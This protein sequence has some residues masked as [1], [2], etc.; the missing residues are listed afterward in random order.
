MW[1]GVTQVLGDRQILYGGEQYGRTD[2]FENPNSALLHSHSLHKLQDHERVLN[3]QKN[4]PRLVVS[5]AGSV[6]GIVQESFFYAV[7]ILSPSCSNNR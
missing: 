7:P 1:R 3:L 6:R 2:L 4:Q 5:D